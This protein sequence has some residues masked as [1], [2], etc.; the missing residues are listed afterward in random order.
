MG[1]KQEE[2]NE[3]KGEIMRKKQWE[4]KSRYETPRQ[5]IREKSKITRGRESVREIKTV[6]KGNKT[7]FIKNKRKKCMNEY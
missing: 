4:E 7:T 3:K 1:G 5:G 6:K 2:N